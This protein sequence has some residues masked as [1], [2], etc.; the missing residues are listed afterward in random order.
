MLRIGHGQVKQCDTQTETDQKFHD[1]TG[2]RREKHELH[3]FQ[4]HLYIFIAAKIIIKS[5]S[6]TKYIDKTMAEQMIAHNDQFA[7][8]LVTLNPHPCN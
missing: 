4:L 2:T 7:C 1:S 3:T 5:L 6:K 8:V